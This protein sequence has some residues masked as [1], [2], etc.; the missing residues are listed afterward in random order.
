LLINKSPSLSSTSED[1]EDKKTPSPYKKKNI[2]KK[3]HSKIHYDK[4]FYK[5]YHCLNFIKEAGFKSLNDTDKI[6]IDY[7]NVHKYCR[8]NE[9]AIR[10]VFER[11]K[12]MVWSDND[13]ELE[14]NEKKALSKYINQKLEAIFSV[15][16]TPTSKGSS[17]YEINKMFLL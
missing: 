16:L 15:R 8:E 6:K 14:T 13:N 11:S 4:T 1:E 7:S 3:I 9:E 17:K 5:I 10:A 12:I 2:S